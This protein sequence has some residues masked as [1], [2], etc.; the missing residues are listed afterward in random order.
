MLRSR[1]LAPILVLSLLA[2]TGCSSPLRITL[3]NDSGISV[4]VNLG[5]TI[6][7]I[8]PGQSAEFAYPGSQESVFRLQRGAC[9]Y[10]YKVPQD[11]EQIPPS[12]QP[13]YQIPGGLKAQIEKGLEI[14]LL[15]ASSKSVAPI[16]SVAELQRIGFPL[17]PSSEHCH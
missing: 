12:A 3:F 9:E 14:L 10:V 16:D 1:I 11:L 5:E 4:A 15:P 2:A 13:S 6:I 17:R 8:D 7:P